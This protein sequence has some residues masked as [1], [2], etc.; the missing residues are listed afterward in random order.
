MC[1]A[2]VV[3]FR[4]RSILKVKAARA[5]GDYQIWRNPMRARLIRDLNKTRAKG[6]RSGLIACDVERTCRWAMSVL[7][8]LHRSEVPAGIISARQGKP[9][10]PA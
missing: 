6:A 4:P 10:G 1:V 7:L 9:G 3:C 2:G 5:G 8:A